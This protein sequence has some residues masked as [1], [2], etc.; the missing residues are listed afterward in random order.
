MEFGVHSDLKVDRIG[1]KVFRVPT[2]VVSQG[3]YHWFGL[4]KVGYR[5]L[6]LYHVSSLMFPSQDV[7]FQYPFVFIYSMADENMIIM[8]CCVFSILLDILWK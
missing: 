5:V 4:E 3:Q 8:V 7:S 1:P 6:F 2:T